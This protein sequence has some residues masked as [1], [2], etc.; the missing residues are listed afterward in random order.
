MPAAGGQAQTGGSVLATDLCGYAGHT[1]MQA[2]VTI[3]YHILIYAYNPY[4]IFIN[5][6][7]DYLFNWLTRYY[8]DLLTLCT[9]NH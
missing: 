6:A 8:G 5:L 1:V 7:L 2:G 4:S 9:V 3:T